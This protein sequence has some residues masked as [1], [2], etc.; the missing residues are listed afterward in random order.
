MEWQWYEDDMPEALGEP[1]QYGPER[2][3]PE[4]EMIHPEEEEPVDPQATWSEQEVP[5]DVRQDIMSK[6]PKETRQAVRKA[7]RGLGHP[8]RETFIR[9][10]RL[11]GHGA[12]TTICQALAVPNMCRVSTSEEI[13]ASHVG[14][15][16]VR[17]QQGVGDRPEVPQGCRAR[18]AGGAQYG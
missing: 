16:P 3:V 15:P 9:M 6:V 13:F 10:L 14:D 18:P 7:H 4:E 8:S 1:Q 12:G 11:G 5:T 17:I 2:S